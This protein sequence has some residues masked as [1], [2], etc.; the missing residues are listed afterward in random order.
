MDNPNAVKRMQEQKGFAKKYLA[1]FEEGEAILLSSGKEGL[2]QCGWHHVR[3]A[4]LVTAEDD[5]P[6][7]LL[8]ALA[9]LICREDMYLFSGELQNMQ[10]TVRLGYRMDGSSANGIH[11]VSVNGDGELSVKRMMYANHMEAVCA[12]GK[13]PFSFP[14]QMAWIGRNWNKGPSRL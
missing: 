6:E 4:V 3:E 14:W 9:P 7:T 12:P 8:E 13:A 5:S 11:A 2:K 1:G 10:L